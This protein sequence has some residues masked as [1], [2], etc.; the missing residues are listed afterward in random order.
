MLLD[1]TGHA[2]GVADKLA[3]HA[4]DTPLHL[5]FSC[6][7]F[8]EHGR[9]LLTRRAW[10]KPTWPGVWTNSCCGHPLPGERPADAVRRRLRDELG[11]EVVDLDLVL[12]GFR[13]LARM[14]NGIVENEMCPV[15]RARA[16]AVPVP[17]P[18]EVAEFDWVDWPMF[19]KQVRAGDRE[20]S[21]WCALQVEQLAE[22]G[23]SPW[24]WPV[25][26]PAGLPPAARL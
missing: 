8:D 15:F 18:A 2:T 21:P 14:A 23:A 7:V 20:V 12:P 4:A 3:I 16:T 24:E 19:A 1:E 6:Y 10:S 5:A 26:D 22:L 9:F 25:G 17:N 13:Y 11:L